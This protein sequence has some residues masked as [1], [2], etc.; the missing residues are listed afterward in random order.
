[1]ITMKILK[2]QACFQHVKLSD[3]FPTVSQAGES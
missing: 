2:R 3:E 1:M